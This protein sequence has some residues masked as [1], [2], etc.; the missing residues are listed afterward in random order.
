MSAGLPVADAPHLRRGARR[1]RTLRA[2]LTAAMVLLVATAAAVASRDRV[3]GAAAAAP[4]G[5]STEVVLDVSGSV[6]TSSSRVAG[7]ALAR[8]GRSRGRV[9]LVLFSDA[10]EEA[11]PPGMP[12][13]QLLP[14]ARALTPPR[15]HGPVNLSDRRPAGAAN[16]WHPTFS[17]GT[18]ISI[19]LHRAREAL[20]HSGGG[21]SVLLISDLGDASNDLTAVRRELVALDRDRVDVKILALPNALSSDVAWFRRVEGG[22]SVVRKVRPAPDRRLA[23]AAVGFPVAAAGIASLLALVLAIDALASRSLRWGSAR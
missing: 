2:G 15:K 1:E 22:G 10:G 21:G 13:A 23:A 17:G 4:G 18:T 6:G 16:P 9:G 7:Q 19:G 5:R 11:L 3:P 12:A 8:L 20:E 14:F